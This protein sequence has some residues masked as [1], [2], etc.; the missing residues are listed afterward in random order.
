[1]HGAEGFDHLDLGCLMA[2]KAWLGPGHI[3]NCRTK[4]EIDEYFQKRKERA[5]GL[6]RPRA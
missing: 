1:L 2:R 4:E 6:A 3:L 5:R